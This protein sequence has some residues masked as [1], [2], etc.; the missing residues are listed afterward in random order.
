M[1]RAR[2]LLFSG[3]FLHFLFSPLLSSSHSLRL[4]PL[5]ADGGVQH[6]E[7]VVEVVLA[8]DVHL[9]ERLLVLVGVVDQEADDAPQ[10]WRWVKFLVITPRAPAGGVLRP[11]GGALHQLGIH[12]PQGLEPPA[13]EAQQAQEVLRKELPRYIFQRRMCIDSELRAAIFVA[14]GHVHCTRFHRVI[15][16][17]MN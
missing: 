12:I 16:Q 17:E 3:L 10:S 2:W 14:S 6:V 9:S 8:G 5:R 13:V 7:P 4:A 15:R 1:H 11:S